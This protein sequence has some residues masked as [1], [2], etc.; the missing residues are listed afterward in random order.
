MVDIILAERE[1]S[2]PP[3]CDIYR[4][5]VAGFCYTTGGMGQEK[6]RLDTDFRRYD[7]GGGLTLRQAH[8][9]REGEV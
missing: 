9:E 2:T 5:I 4:L 7:W 3:K 6:R 8:H 1:I